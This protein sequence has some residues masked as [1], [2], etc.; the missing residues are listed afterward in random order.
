MAEIIPTIG[1]IVIYT[2]SADD[3]AKINKRRDDAKLHM[4]NHRA[5]SN[6]VMVHVGEPVYVGQEFP[7]MI[8]AVRGARSD[9][10][11]S[12]KVELDGSDTF[13]APGRQVGTQP[14]T[15]R[16]MEYQ[17]GQ[18]AKTE[19]LEAKFASGA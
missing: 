19:A 1:R 9:S 6:G 13:W 17:K 7:M 4:D 12:G 10:T 5:N 15:Y 11:I 16:W 14:G 18:A 8:V 3:A 2:L